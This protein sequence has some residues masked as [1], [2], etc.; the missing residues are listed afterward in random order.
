MDI[1][2]IATIATA[3][4]GSG[5]Q[6]GCEAVSRRRREHP[7]PVVTG[8]SFTPAREMETGLL[9]FVR[10]VVDGLIEVDCVSVRRTRKG[11]L[12]L[13]FPVRE[14]NQGRRHP[15]LKPKNDRAR[16]LLEQLVLEQLRNVAEVAP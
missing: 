2:T 13:S 7:L 4:P 15:V 9:G 3:E 10:F 12:A 1:A 8:V 14:D 11:N 6:R 5:D 16:L